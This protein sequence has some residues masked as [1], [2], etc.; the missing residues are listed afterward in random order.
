MTAR[1]I[2]EAFWRAGLQLGDPRILGVIL[3]SVA[4][5]LGITAPFALIFVGLA[6][7]IELLTP[8]TLSLPWIGEVGFLGLLTDGLTNRASWVFWTYAMSPLAVAII[9]LFL[10]R[11]IDAVER[12]H[13]PGAPAVKARGVLEMTVYAIR[14]FGVMMI[15]NL[16]ALLASLLAGPLAPLIFVA[17]NGFLL[18]REYYEAVALR[19]ITQAEMTARRAR[20]M[21]VLWAAGAALSLGLVVP[22]ANLLVPAL[23]AAAFTHLFY[24]LG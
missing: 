18:A 23:G 4:I 21:P 3:A 8:A 10:D 13:Y 22:F 16:G 24:R 9:G 17:A 14:F 2:A 6:W 11:I 5:M 12:R 1:P 20:H 15:V 7:V 19:R